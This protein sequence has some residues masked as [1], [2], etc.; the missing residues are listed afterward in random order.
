MEGHGRGP[1]FPSIFYHCPAENKT[2]Y[3]GGRR[4]VLDLQIRHT[5]SSRWQEFT[6]GALNEA[7]GQQLQRPPTTSS[8]NTSALVLQSPHLLTVSPAKSNALISKVKGF[9]CY[10]HTHEVFSMKHHFFF[11]LLIF[12]VD[13]GFLTRT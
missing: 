1:P 6:L 2:P 11:F 3:K 12:W 10:K 13:L 8:H 9:E 7:G 4:K 5:V